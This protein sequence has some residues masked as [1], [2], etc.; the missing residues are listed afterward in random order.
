M[1]EYEEGDIVI[2]TVDR[3]IGTSVFVKLDSQE[4][5]INFSEVAPGRIRNIRDYINVGQKIVVKVIRVD[6]EKKNIDLSLRRVTL[7][8]KK[9]VLENEKKEKELLTLIKLAT[10]QDAKAQEI[11]D[12]I[13][14]TILITEFFEN[15]H[16]KE[17]K[18][19]IVFLKSSGLSDSES[20]NLFDLLKEKIKEKRVKI[21]IEF[22]LHSNAENGIEKVKK[23]LELNNV[24][25]KYLGAPLYSITIEDS[26]YKDGNKKMKKALEILEQKAKEE[27]CAFEIKHRL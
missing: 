18:D 16:K 12:K 23:V 20:K 21:K 4:G 17:E 14:S 22:S 27:S 7:K 15:I 5:V 9:E 25:I 10:K 13:K 1:K 8:E 6:K 24:Q 2:G 3:L 26:N 11:L 19:N